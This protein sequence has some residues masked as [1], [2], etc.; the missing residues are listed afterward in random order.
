MFHFIPQLTLNI[1][2]NHCV[3]VCLRLYK[4]M[5][6]TYI[7]YQVINCINKHF[8]SAVVYGTGSLTCVIL[9]R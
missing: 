2:L 5:I 1:A 8:K 3:I 6:Y 9:G 7:S 4:L